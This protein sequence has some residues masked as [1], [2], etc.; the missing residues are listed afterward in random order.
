M[1]GWRAWLA[2]LLVGLLPACA[3]ADEAPACP[4]APVVPIAAPRLAAAI[5]GGEE[6]RIVALGSS[7]TAGAGASLPWRAYPGRLEARLR[8]A[9]PGTAVTVMNRG[10]GGEDAAH[11]LGRLERDAVAERPQLVI[12]QVGANAA[13]RS[14]DRDSFR[15][16]LRQGLL[17]LRVAGID[18]VLMDNQRAPR[19][20]AR[21]GH[22][23][24]DTMLAEAAA[25]VPGVVLFSRGALMDA[26]AAN[27]VPNEAFLISDN[28]HHNDRGYACIAEAISAALMA[29]LPPGT[30][31]QRR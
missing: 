10:A 9:L 18:V 15:S 1:T 30:P 27:G 21:P 19:I 20:A 14:M 25:G 5:A 16:F 22:R 13:L 29:G 12:W 26:W 24:Y 8:A 23:D 11:M 17:R 31:A 3:R 2:A 28:L 4:P 7:S 6:V